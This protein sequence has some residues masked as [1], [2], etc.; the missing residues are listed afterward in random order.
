VRPDAQLALLDNDDFVSI[1]P[2]RRVTIQAG[3]S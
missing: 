2:D 3:P 1:D